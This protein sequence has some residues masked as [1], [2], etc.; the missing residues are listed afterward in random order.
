MN[1]DQIPTVSLIAH[2]SEC[3]FYCKVIKWLTAFAVCEAVA[4]GAFA[5]AMA[6]R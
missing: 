1:E 5:L 4:F 2:E 3:A 6:I